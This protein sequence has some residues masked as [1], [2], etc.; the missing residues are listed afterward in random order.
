MK[1][2]LSTYTTIIIGSEMDFVKSNITAIIHSNVRLAW[3]GVPSE[4]IIR[5]NRKENSSLLY[6][7]AS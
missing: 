3:S 1:Q 6:V 7:N 2:Q 4:Y 5:D